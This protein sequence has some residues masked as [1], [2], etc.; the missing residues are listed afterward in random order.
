MALT[1]GSSWPGRRR[2][3]TSPTARS[4]SRSL[5]PG[6]DEGFD[7]LSAELGLF[8]D[9]GSPRLLALHDVA[10]DGG[11][12]FYAMRHQVL[13]SLASP[14]REVPRR[15]RLAAVAR[16]ADAAHELHEAGIV[17][18]AIK[19]SNIFLDPAGAVLAEPRSPTW[20][21]TGSR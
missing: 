13:G 5:V 3:S 17:H 11:T 19:P 7:A 20:S 6:T 14:T 16:A 2:G 15:E 9:V 12:L 18:R 4:R 8:A 21:R 1:A 10:M